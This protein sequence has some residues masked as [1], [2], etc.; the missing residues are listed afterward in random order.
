[1]RASYLSIL[2]ILPLSLA[3]PIHNPAKPF[4]QRDLLGTIADGAAKLINPNATAAGIAGAVKQSIDN[5]ALTGGA[6]PS[7]PCSLI[8]R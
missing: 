2:A 8:S 5:P 4:P 1:M 6:P 3:A 7:G